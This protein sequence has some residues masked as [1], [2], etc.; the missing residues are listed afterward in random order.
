M[1]IRER[2]EAVLKTLEDKDERSV[3][4]GLDLVEKLDP[5]DRCGAVASRPAPSLLSCGQ[6]LER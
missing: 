5:N 2:I 6:E 4:F 3:L 1:P